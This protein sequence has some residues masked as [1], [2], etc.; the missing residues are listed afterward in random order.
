MDYQD[1][2]QWIGEELDSLLEDITGKE[3]A[4]RRPSK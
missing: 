1:R 2:V 3:K 4:E